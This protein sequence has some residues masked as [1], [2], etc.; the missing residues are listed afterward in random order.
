MQFQNCE[1][2]VF[3]IIFGTARR[4]DV[5]N[6]Q[7]HARSFRLERLVLSDINRTN[8]SRGDGLDYKV[9]GNGIF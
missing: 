6:L 8:A 3:P 1:I 9:F 2:K 7:L 4:A 5:F